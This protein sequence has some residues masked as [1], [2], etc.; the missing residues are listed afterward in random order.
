MKNV[1]HV[2]GVYQISARVFNTNNERSLHNIGYGFFGSSEASTCLWKDI[3]FSDHHDLLKVGKDSVENIAGL[4]GSSQ[5]KRRLKHR[6][7]SESGNFDVDSELLPENDFDEKDFEDTDTGRIFN[8]PQVVTVNLDTQTGSAVYYIIAANATSNA[9]LHIGGFGSKDL[10]EIVG[11]FVLFNASSPSMLVN[12]CHKMN[13][14]LTE[15]NESFESFLVICFSDSKTADMQVMWHNFK[16]SAADFGAGSFIG[17]LTNSD[18]TSSEQ[19]TTYDL[20]CS[21][22]PFVL[23]EVGNLYV[24]NATISDNE[25]FAGRDYA[26]MVIET[27][28]SAGRARRHYVS[29]EVDDSDEILLPHFGSLQFRHDEAGSSHL[30]SELNERYHSNEILHVPE[31]TTPDR[32]YQISFH[33]SSEVKA[34]LAGGLGHFSFN[35]TSGVIGVIKA[36]DYETTKQTA[37]NVSLCPQVRDANTRR[38]SCRVMNFTVKVLDQNDNAPVFDEEVY[39]ASVPSDIAAHSKIL[40]VH[41]KDKDSGA[42]GDISYAL[43]S[44]S[45]KFS[46]DY[47][48]GYLLTTAPLTSSLYNLTV[49]AFDHGRPSHSSMVNV[50][51]TVDSENLHAPEFWEFL[52]WAEIPEDAPVGSFLIQLNAS[53]PDEGPEGMLSYRLVDPSSPPFVIDSTNGVVITTA[54]L[55]YEKEQFYQLMVEVSDHGSFR[56]SSRTLLVVSVVDVNDNAPVLQ[57]LPDRIFIS[58]A[59][60]PGTVIFN[61]TADDADS[62]LHGNNKLSYAVDNYDTPDMFDISPDTHQLRVKRK[63]RKGRFRINIIARDHGNPSLDTG[64]WVTVEVIASN[65]MFPVFKQLQYHVNVDNCD[66]DLP[67]RRM[68]KA[69]V[70]KGDVVYEMIPEPRGLELNAS[71]GELLVHPEFCRYAETSETRLII[72]A[73]NSLSKSH[74]SDLTV[75]LLVSARSNRSTTQPLRFSAPLYRAIV[76]ENAPV[77]SE[78]DPGFPFAVTSHSTKLSY[79]LEPGKYFTID[80]NGKVFVRQLI[81]LE[82]LPPS[83]HGVITEKVSMSDGDRTATSV[84]EI[85]VADVNEFCPSF[86]SEHFTATVYEVR[87]FFN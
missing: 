66:S 52:Y 25:S 43:A 36:F 20:V 67:L 15:D 5:M 72:R 29:V 58:Q 61:V 69:L 62:S 18:K 30:P 33:N 83:Q 37:F 47:A 53:D 55:D 50:V 24:W 19:S 11:N 70:P 35:S 87:E 13:I 54:P 60:E 40:Q 21:S 10:L 8:L 86:L 2:A 26:F 48:T 22:C 38:P 14:V 9:T 79:S 68:F 85:K 57:P 17:S 6:E 44:S 65:S 42:N 64:H 34:E 49:V 4:S 63:L 59:E 71:S 73:T 7:S 32:L 51:V 12:T 28:G 82:K 80:R 16:L 39:Y 81:D 76:K 31:N 74:Y 45:S 78:V 84:I 1:L 77:G 46:M 41:A 75:A 3:D 23:D 27:K 56:R